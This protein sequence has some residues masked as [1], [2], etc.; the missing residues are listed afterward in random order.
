MRARKLLAGGLFLLSVVPSIGCRS[1]ADYLQPFGSFGANADPTAVIST[2]TPILADGTWSERLGS[3]LGMVAV[4]DLD[5][6]KDPARYAQ[7]FATRLPIQEILTPSEA[8]NR[9]PRVS[10]GV[11]Q[12]GAKLVFRSYYN[13]GGDITLNALKLGEMKGAHTGGASVEVKRL[14]TARL[15]YIKLE[16]DFKKLRDSICDNLA[17]TQ[18]ALWF[19]GFTVYEVT[20]QAYSESTGEV[21]I[22]YGGFS[23]N[24]K[25]FNKSGNEVTRLLVVPD[26]AIP[27]YPSKGVQHQGADEFQWPLQWR[28]KAVSV[29]P[30]VQKG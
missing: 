6:F 22:G 8:K 4:I 14:L 23:A 2:Q 1:A 9:P 17:P 25:I 19:T 24:G 30:D 21:T 26:I 12:G 5:E 27:W 29:H 20:W 7:T 3:I 10:I 18:I 28:G 11:P 15:D 16:E 13:D